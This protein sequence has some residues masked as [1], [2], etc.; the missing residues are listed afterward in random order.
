MS[1]SASRISLPETAPAT[2][3][4]ARYL[5]GIDRT[6][7]A[8]AIGALLLLGAVVLRDILLLLFAA[9]LIACVLHGAADWLH[10]HAGLSEGWSLT[11]VVAGLLLALG[12]L[13]W[14]RGPAM[15][16]QAGQMIDQLAGQLRRVWSV[17][18][19]LGWAGSI[20]DNLREASQKIGAGVT[21][22]VT[23]FVSSTLG[24][25]GTLVVVIATALFLAAS[26][27]LYIGGALRLIPVAWRPRGREVMT[28]IGHDLQ[29]WFVGQ[30]AD[31]AVVTLLAGAGLFALGVP[32]APTLALFAGLLNFVPYVGAL[33]GAVPAVL[34]GLSQSP[35]QALWVAL[36]F[37][38][39]QMLEGNVIAPLIQRRTISLPPA[40][41]ILSQTLLGTLFGALGLILATPLM[42][43]SLVAVRMIYVETVLEG[44]RADP[45][46]GHPAAGP[47]CPA[48]SAAACSGT[49]PSPP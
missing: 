13:V 10:R 44:R 43:A 6:L 37:L 29:L 34:V 7:R 8:A 42:A 24:I 5:R 25:T 31:M 40:L 11:A 45:A 2:D 41:T 18:D 28:G 21:G 15:A 16:G 47:T 26:P 35:N 19:D 30:L 49:R 38:A 32:L 46:S 9:V 23:G 4:R 27:R 12:A 36:L 22:Y 17:M 39:V 33:A 20:A 3:E 48:S 14:W 1:C